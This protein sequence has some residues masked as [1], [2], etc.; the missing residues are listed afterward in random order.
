MASRKGARGRWRRALLLLLLGGSAAVAL[1]TF[2]TWPDV[3]ALKTANPK[4][5]AF[6]EAWKRQ[7][8]AAGKPDDVALRFV[9][10]RQ[11]S[12]HLKRAAIVAE[13]I[14]FFSHEGFDVGEIRKALAD[15]WDEREFPRGASTISQQLVKNLWLSPSRNPLRKVKEALLT[16][17]L[18]RTLD[19]R[20]ILE[21]YLNVAE[22]GPGVYGAEAAGRRYFGRSAAVLD[23]DQAARLAAALTRPRSWHPG[24]TTRGYERRVAAVRRRMDKAAWLW[25]VI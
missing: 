20:R 24:V 4:T 9:P 18:E 17:Q 11:I 23:E 1:W 10:Y 2:A 19:K 14:E 6:I 5:T 7:Q 3:A 22:F 8:R 25:K 16:R 13:D 15:A 12:P 21:L